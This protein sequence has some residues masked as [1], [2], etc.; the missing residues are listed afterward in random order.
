MSSYSEL[1]KDPRWQRKR[2]LV[3][4]RDGFACTECGDNKSEL[5]VHH[6]YYAKDRD[7][8]EYEDFALATLCDPCHER[9]EQLRLLLVKSAG[10]LDFEKSMRVVGYAEGL[11]ASERIEKDTKIVFRGVLH[12]VGFCDAMCIDADA[13]LACFSRDGEAS[14]WELQRVGTK[15]SAA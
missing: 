9:A 8:W 4:E 6:R 3:L 10:L 13:A 14:A 2:L 15:R 11:V 1:L 12:L 5:Q 7:P